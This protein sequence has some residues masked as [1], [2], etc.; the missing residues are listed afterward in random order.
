MKLQQYFR[1]SVI[2]FEGTFP[3]IGPMFAQDLDVTSYAMWRHRL[4]FWLVRCPGFAFCAGVTVLMDFD[5][6]PGEFAPSLKLS[7]DTETWFLF[8]FGF[9]VFPRV[10]MLQKWLNLKNLFEKN[11]R[12]RR[13]SHWLHPTLTLRHLLRGEGQSGVFSGRGPAPLPLFGGGGD[14]FCCERIR[15]LNRS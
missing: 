8:S 12:S 4:S 13:K 5:H 7:C 2:E 14:C 15:A 3:W 9:K 1:K 10:R 11:K 6:L